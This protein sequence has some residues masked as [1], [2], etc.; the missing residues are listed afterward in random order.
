MN[1]GFF[2]ETEKGLYI[3]IAPWPNE[4]N[5][6]WC[7]KESHKSLLRD[8]VTDEEIKNRLTQIL[9]PIG[10]TELKVLVVGFY[11]GSV[12]RAVREVAKELKLKIYLFGIDPDTSS[13]KKL[14][15]DTKLTIGSISKLDYKNN[16]FDLVIAI[17]IFEHLILDDVLC[18]FNEIKKVLKIK[19]ALYFETTNPHSLLA[20]TLDHDWWLNVEEMIYTLFSPTRLRIIL[21]E[22][23][24][25]NIK[26]KTEIKKSKEIDEIREIFLHSENLIIKLVKIYLKFARYQLLRIYLKI[27][28]HGSIITSLV[29]K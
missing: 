12:L 21:S 4:V 26:I 13:I 28:N 7:L 22:N 6:N 23:G 14:D 1:K 10:N 18:L 16:F 29:T 17:N 20:N 27:F 8:K 5:P 3:K 25:S 15:H 11:K 24:F 19:G 9:K 2:K